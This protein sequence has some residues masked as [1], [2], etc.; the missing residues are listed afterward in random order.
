MM[1]FLL[2][3]K[4]PK[5]FRK[6]LL[7]E[8]L[9]VDRD[10]PRLSYLQLLSKMKYPKAFNQQITTSTRILS[11]VLAPVYIAGYPNSLKAS[12]ICLYSIESLFESKD[13]KAAV[14]KQSKIIRRRLPCNAVVLVVVKR[15]S[16]GNNY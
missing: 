5:Q 10:I 2:L 1:S 4:T 13:K 15:I 11:Q 16:H 6:Q 7:G 9:E 14:G 8:R 3:F 12:T